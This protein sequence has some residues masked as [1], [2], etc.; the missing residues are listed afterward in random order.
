MPEE[1]RENTKEEEFT[2]ESQGKE[3]KFKRKIL[4]WYEE[5]TILNQCSNI[6]KVKKVYIV[7]VPEMTLKTMLKS[8]TEAPFEI[9]EKNLKELSKEVKN[10][11]MDRIKP[12]RLTKEQEKK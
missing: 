5:E 1:L 11:I 8:L 12:K 2:I 10:K 4:T 3:F 7:N 9:N 6:D